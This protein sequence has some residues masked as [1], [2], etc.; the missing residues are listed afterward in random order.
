MSQ[1]KPHWNDRKVTLNGK[2]YITNNGQWYDSI[3]KK[4]VTKEIAMLPSKGQAL[5]ELLNQS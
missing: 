3:T 1:Y 4:N 2:I 5:N